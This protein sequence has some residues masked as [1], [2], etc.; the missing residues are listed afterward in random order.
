MPP[1]WKI[2]AAGRRRTRLSFILFTRESTS[3]APP[4]MASGI[5]TSR[6]VSALLL[7]SLAA[8]PSFSESATPATAPVLMV[9]DI[10]FEPFWDPAKAAQLAAAPASDWT[11]I[12]ASAPSP[13]R[14]ARFDALKQACR[15]RGDDTSYP[16]YASS[17]NAIKTNAAGAK[18]VTVSGDLIS[19]SFT[20]KYARVFPNAKPGDYRAFVEKTIEYVV[21]S[22]R[23][24][25]PGVP[26]YAS[27][28]NN[29]SDCGDYQLDANS[30]FLDDTGKVLTADVPAAE[31]KQTRQD[32]AI[33]GNFSV[34]LPAPFTRSRLIILD[35]VFM[36]RKY[37]TCAGKDD[38]SEARR[39]IAWLRTQLD[40]ARQEN[41]KVWVMTHIPPGIDALGTAAKGMS[42]CAGK[43]PTMFLKSDD[44]PNALAPYG[45]VIA[46]AIFAHTHMDEMRLLIPAGAPH[47]DH[48]VPV[49]VVSSISPIDGNNPSITVAQVDPR[50]ATLID[51]R[52]IAASNQTGID[53]N[54]A[55]EYDYAQTYSGPGFSDTALATLIGEFRADTGA[56]SPA[57]QAYLRNYFV[58]DRSSILAPF[59]PIATCGLI[60]MSAGSFRACACSGH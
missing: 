33:G 8:A 18:F 3:G 23:K 38:S 37:Q 46:L 45:D 16:L 54:W 50:T 1:I 51:Y 59:W 20:C 12:L 49:K 43:D 52:V 14:E 9:S 48:A 44:L 36:A 34:A 40:H 25:L 29:D 56:K 57:S 24:A 31:L 5:Q 10:H 28:G 27:L 22:L 41:E 13:D 11:A 60:N 17:L 15:T 4:A 7:L 30:G 39:Q 6:L 47:P 55:E 19:H 21:G 58:G 32:F 35:D 2:L 42:I 26:V 53:T